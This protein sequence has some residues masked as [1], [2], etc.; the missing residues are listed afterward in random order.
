MANTKKV[1]APAANEAVRFSAGAAEILAADAARLAVEDEALAFRDFYQAIVVKHA[2]PLGALLPRGKDEPRRSNEEQAA[3]DFGVGMFYTYLFGAD[4]AG[5]IAD[6]NVKSDVV[7]PISQFVG[8][9]GRHYKDQAKRAIT[10]SFGGTPWKEFVSRMLAIE[11]EEEKAAKVAAGLMTQAE[12]DAKE[13]RGTGSKKTERERVLK[14]VSDLC[15]L[16]RK[17]ADKRDGS[18][19]A[20]TGAAF[21]TVLSDQASAHGFK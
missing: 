7:L 8:R 2:L 12:A 19:D 10:Q 21:A 18:V 1:A 13:K 15:T 14:M 3:Y 6:R 20:K 4:I 16:L 5:K 11:E 17:S 9:T